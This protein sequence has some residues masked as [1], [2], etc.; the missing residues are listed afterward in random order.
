MN[1]TPRP[2]QHDLSEPE[3]Y[4]LS[5]AP[6]YHF[7]LDRRDFLK[8]LGGGLLVC[9][10]V[11]NV[12]EVRAQRGGFG[13]NLPKEVGAWLHISEAGQVTVY[14]GKVEVGQNSRTSLSA[15][16]AEELRLPVTALKLVM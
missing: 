9:L 1:A 2:D 5:E 8:T 7:D 12:G 16:V 14:T 11:E 6:R 15:V 10:L 4:E 13:G 3:R